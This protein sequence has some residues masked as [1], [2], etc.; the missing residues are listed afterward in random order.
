MNVPMLAHLR[1][2]MQKSNSTGMEIF[3]ELT[4]LYDVCIN[5]KQNHKLEC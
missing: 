2:L 5:P 1:E 4:L 3:K